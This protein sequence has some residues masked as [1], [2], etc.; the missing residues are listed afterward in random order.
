LQQSIDCYSF[1]TCK[2]VKTI[3]ILNALNILI[4]ISG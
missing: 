3:K 4:I 1:M 2:R